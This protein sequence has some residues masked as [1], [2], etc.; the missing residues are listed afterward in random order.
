MDHNDGATTGDSTTPSAEEPSLK[1][2]PTRQ[3][4]DETVVPIVQHALVALNKERPA[5]PIDFL[6]NYLLREKGRF[7]AMA[8]KNDGSKKPGDGSDGDS[9]KENQAPVPTKKQTRSSKK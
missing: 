9:N 1:S 2:V 5:E 3:Y 7:E 6:A 8:K 4:L